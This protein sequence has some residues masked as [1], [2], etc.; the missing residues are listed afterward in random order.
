MTEWIDVV[1]EEYRT[2]RAESLLAMQTQQSVLRFGLGSV[3]VV[4][5]AGFTSW[6]QIN[7]ASIVFLVLLPLICYAVLII[8]IGE[9]ARMIRAGYFLL[10]LEEKINQKFLSQY[11]NETK[12]L[13]WETYLRNSNGISGTPQLQW[14]YLIIIALFFLLAFI[15]IVV[16]NINLW[17]STYR[18]QLIW[19]NLFELFFFTLVFIYIFVTGKR[20]K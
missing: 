14:N 4:I 9:V 19:V 17:S 20:F 1:L 2:L 13:S 8:W 15:S 11:P 7:L 16:G 3:G 18:D 5:G 10:Q 6:N 12:P